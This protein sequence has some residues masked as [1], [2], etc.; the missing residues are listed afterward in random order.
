MLVIG[1]IGVGSP[2]E[3]LIPRLRV[4]RDIAGVV[5]V[6]FMV[7]PGDDPRT[8]RVHLLQRRIG[9]VERIAVSV[10]VEGDNFGAVM[11]ANGLLFR[12][13]FVDIV[14]KEDHKIRLIG[15][16]VVIGGIETV[17]PALAG[18]EGKPQ[19]LLH[20]AGAWR[21]ESAAY[22]THFFAC[23]ELV[24]IRPVGLQ[25]RYLHVHGVAQSS[26]R[27]TP[28]PAHHAAH[29]IVFGD[30]PVNGNRITPHATA[31]DR[32]GSEAGPQH[33]AIGCRVTRSHTQGERIT[34]ERGRGVN[35][36]GKGGATQDEQAARDRH[37]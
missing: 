16:H 33:K 28:A 35:R 4:F 8:V 13:V 31:M 30:L 11:R 2:F 23:F 9:A 6:H 25:A 1:L 12:P 18:S 29:G 32:V 37:T 20:V 19:R 22:R 21:S 27:H 15:Q 3:E 34:A 10:I 17:V 26:R 24:P 7:V 5:V 14:A 36:G